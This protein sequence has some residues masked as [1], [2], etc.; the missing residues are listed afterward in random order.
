M[1]EQAAPPA[2]S[3]GLLYFLGGV[4]A[5]AILG[6]CAGVILGARPELREGLVAGSRQARQAQAALDS[7]RRYG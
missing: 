4:A 6:L 5:G 3:P 1:S 2:A 7:M